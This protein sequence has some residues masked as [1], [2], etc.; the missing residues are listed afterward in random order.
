MD[1][2]AFYVNLFVNQPAWSTPEPNPDEAARW[3]KMASFLSMC[4]VTRKE[5]PS[6]ALPP[7]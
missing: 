4:S 6:H 7:R 1:Q 2:N 5:D 3:S